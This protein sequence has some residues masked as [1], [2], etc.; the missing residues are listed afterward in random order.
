MRLYLQVM[1]LT[2]MFVLFELHVSCDVGHVC[3]KPHMFCESGLKLLLWSFG[4]PTL[5]I[6]IYMLLKRQEVIISRIMYS[7]L[8]VIT[9]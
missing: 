2:N 8:I 9:K 7:Q 5:Y 4:V 6:Y 1:N 3:S